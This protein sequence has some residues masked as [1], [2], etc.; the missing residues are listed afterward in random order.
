MW[1]KSN[2]IFENFCESQGWASTIKYLNPCLSKGIGKNNRF[3]FITSHNVTFMPKTT[4]SR[5][6]VKIYYQIFLLHQFVTNIR[7]S[8]LPYN[9]HPKVLSVSC[10]YLF[11]LNLS[12]KDQCLHL[13]TFMQVVLPL[14]V[15]FTEKDKKF[16]FFAKAVLRLSS[17]WFWN[18]YTSMA[19]VITRRQLK[20]LLVDEAR[21]NH[22]ISGY[23]ANQIAPFQPRDTKLLF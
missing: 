1:H 11:P 6:K 13:K 22:P 12:T 4:S 17:K 16:L 5:T 8:N 15:K 3:V 19:S 7:L 10:F 18:T 9:Q 23:S 14:P 2:S 20:S 21:G